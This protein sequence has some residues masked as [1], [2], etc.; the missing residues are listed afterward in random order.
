MKY[1]KK[2]FVL[3]ILVMALFI[4]SACAKNNVPSFDEQGQPI[5]R[6]F[7]N[8]GNEFDGVRKDRIWQEIERNS[9]VSLRIEGATHNSDYYTTLSPMIN[10]GDFPDLVFTVPGDAPNAYANWVNQDI[11][12]N[13]D[14]LLAEKPGEYPWIEK[15]MNSQ[16]YRNISYGEGQRT[17]LPYITSANGWGIYYRKDWLIN[18]GYYDMVNDVKVART[19]VT[20]EEFEEVL[21][22]FTENDPDQN[23]LKDTWG[24]SPHG[25][26]FFLNPLYGAFGVTPNYDIVN[27]EVVYMYLRDEFKNF[28]SWFRNMY[29]SG[30]IDPQFATNNN[31]SDR[32]KF[33]EGKVG[34]LITN[35]EQHVTWVASAFEARNGSDLLMF[36]DAPIGTKNL[37]M[38]GVGG[39]S[40]WGGWW[41]GYSI[42]TAAKNPHAVLRFLDYLY[43]PEGT[44]LRAYG[45]K[46]VH[47]SINNNGEIIPNIE[48]R[49]KEPENTFYMTNDSVTGT[50][51]PTGFYRMGYGFSNMI[52]WNRFE[53][54][55]FVGAKLDPFMINPNYAQ[56]IQEAMTKN[57]LIT[58]RLVNITSYY[59]AF[60]LKMN[61]MEDYIDT[62]IINAIMG[63]RNL[64]TDWNTML[65]TLRQPS[66]DWD[67]IKLMI[68]EVAEQ[69]GVLDD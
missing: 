46:D 51:L 65:T 28:L 6:M 21:R 56:L 42:T 25:E 37:G 19:P 36:G 49:N 30:Y 31:Y 62:Y 61:R 55:G 57:T 9:N 11:F 66:Y 24:L 69:A 64:T 27:N 16:Q 33:Y 53:T 38:E 10:T 52:D 47:Y 35:A 2:V 43:S 41:G 17:L 60:N 45:I 20:I 8:Q 1:R 54:D 13:L 18:V 23:G 48:E 14:I 59:P 29:N 67:N 15:I 5:I 12:V 44:M 39:F 32:D 3:I 26:P 68:M 34:I 50:S 40:N 7:I 58:N 22:L 4:M 63:N